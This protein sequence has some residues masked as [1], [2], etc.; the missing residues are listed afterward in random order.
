M[1]VPR[2]TVI[3][4]TFNEA[5]NL[6]ELARRILAA[7]SGVE[8]LVVDDASKDGTADR[9]RELGLR[10][11][12]RLDER[13]LS[14][15]VLRGLAEAGA[16]I[17]VVMDADLSH[18]P[19]AIP[20][21]LRAVEEGADI[22]VG[23]RYVPGGDIDNWP[24]LR[25]WISL[26]GTALARP[27]TPAR[28]PLAGFFCL[29]RGLLKGVELKPRGFKILLEILA[30]TGCRK[31]AEV[32]IH[33][34]DRAAGESKFGP[35][36]RRDYL[37]QVWTLYRDL[38]AW[39]FW[40]AILAVITAARAVLSAFVPL[41]PEEAYHW[42]YARHLDWGYHDH[43][44]MIAWA[45]AL[46]RLVFGDTPL[47]VR[48]VPIL[49]SAGTAALTASL[50]GKFFGGRA[51]RW[52]VG[53]LSIMPVLFLASGTGFPDSPMLFF[54]ALA[55]TLGWRAMET[56]RGAWWLAAGAAMGAAM[57]SKYTAVFFVPSILLYL[58]FSR[59]DRKW[60][61]TPWPWLAGVAALAVFT[62]V[63][64]WNAVHDWASFRF[65]GVERLRESEG[66]RLSTPVQFLGGQWLGL[67]P[68]TLP[69]AAAALRPAGRRE[70]RFLFWLFA[71]MFA[72]FFLVSWLRPVH[73]MWPM[74]AH[75][76]LAAAMAGAVGRVAAFYRARRRWLF[77]ISAAAMAAGGLH[78]AF[79]LPWFSPLKGLYG[80][81]AAAEKCREAG[82]SLPKGSFVIGYG[83]KYTCAS[84]LAFHLRRPHD[85]HGKNLL[86]LGGLQYEYW[87]DLPRL[88]GKDALV[89]VEGGDRLGA[90]ESLLKKH[91]RSVEPAGE[92]TVP[93]GRSP[94]LETPP[95]RFTFFRA[96]GYRP[97][98]P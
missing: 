93:V 32:P 79:F 6:P 29:R 7:A 39:P 58:L 9:A 50:A 34:E 10:V 59:E 72:F 83:R 45:I 85:V 24:L 37:K 74:P 33:F 54:W 56:R 18:P 75:L 19:E 28:D 4:P 69:L 2:A 70:D 22:A 49:F 81:G 91:F 53:L 36:E 67:L 26:S 89:V 97:P 80:W 60:L 27:L 76:A 40:F 96:R 35:A 95:L 1:T 63:L 14:T 52:T 71:P 13:G 38:N 46:G 77:W 30:R 3:V 98:G 5:K 17:C 84:Q 62:P 16:E 21:L 57:L 68:L 78:A 42:N 20:A 90:A 23:S 8:I 11:V 73:L 15:A 66:I 87:A 86:G 41:V 55:M 51:A 94:L 43:P 82:A 12:E 61:A 88:D 47:G 48:L 44:P 31:I 25:R 64:Y 65:Q 92:L